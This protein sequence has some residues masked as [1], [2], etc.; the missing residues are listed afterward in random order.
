[1][2]R[3]SANLGFLWTE[4]A[5][6]EAVAAAARA[7]FSAVELHWPFETPASQ[8]RAVLERTGLPLLGLNT[9]PGDRAAGD[10]GLAAM[11]GRE[12]EAR[13]AIDQ[14]V[15]YAAAAG[16]R[17]VHVMAGKS[18]W[19]KSAHETF[20]VNVAYAAGRAADRNIGILLEPINQIDAPDYFLS[21]VEQARAIID[22]LGQ[23]NVKIMFDCYHTQIMQGNLL[24]RIERHLDIIGHIQIAAVPSRQE[25]DEGEV[26]YAWLLGAIDA[27]GY[28][29]FIGAEYKPRGDTWGGLSWVETLAGRV[30]SR[31]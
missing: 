24:R 31:G 16:A 20:I 18:G 17:N 13:T 11:A 9:V 10:F 7:G 19:G 5:L 1:M 21:T 15:S 14:A 4:L 29:G 12:R 27:L 26:D 6:T 30:R 25:P 28:E 3:F 23:P 22:E 2:P 8:L